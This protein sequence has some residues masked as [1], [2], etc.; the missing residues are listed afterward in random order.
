[1]LVGRRAFV[2]VKLL[3][4]REAAGMF[5]LPE[6]NLHWYV[7]EMAGD[8][9]VCFDAALAAEYYDAAEPGFRGMG[10][11]E[12]AASDAETYPGMEYTSELAYSPLHRINPPNDYRDDGVHRIQHK[13]K[14]WL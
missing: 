3:L 5:E 11:I 10:R 1:A 12:Q 8:A 13:R 9:A 4:D 7:V 2:E 6:P 14:S